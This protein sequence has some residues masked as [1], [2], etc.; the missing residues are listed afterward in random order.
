MK[1]IKWQWRG[2]VMTDYFFFRWLQFSRHF[3]GVTHWSWTFYWKG[4]RKWY[5]N[6]K[7][8]QSANIYPMRKGFARTA[9]TFRLGKYI[10][11]FSVVDLNKYYRDVQVLEVKDKGKIIYPLKGEHYAEIEKKTGK[12]E[13]DCWHLN[14]AYPNETWRN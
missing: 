6:F 11:S 7:Q 4:S 10:I 2:Q 5:Y 14:K 1:R 3:K 12:I 8:Y 9:L 13:K